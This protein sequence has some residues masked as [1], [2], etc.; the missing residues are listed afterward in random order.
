MYDTVLVS[1]DG[2]LAAEAALWEIE[3]L[4]DGHPAMVILLRVRPEINLDQAVDEMH[5]R[6]VDTT[7]ANVGEEIALLTHSS[8]AEM[9]QYLE[10]I[11]H[12][13]EKAG[14]TCIPEV[15]F[16][17]PATEILYFARHYKAEL[18]AMVTHARWGLDRALHGSVT[19]RVLHHAPCPM[20]ILRVP[21]VALP[22]YALADQS[23]PDPV[24][25]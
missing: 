13:L 24:E 2:S 14:L 11:A 15:S 3:S 20:L 19:E 6:G 10:A 25:A 5:R 1:L 22:R 12:R 16:H 9:W 17:D 21:E 8:E 18:I 7:A 4:L 23:M